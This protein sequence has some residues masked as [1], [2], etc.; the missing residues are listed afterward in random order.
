M[1]NDS[2]TP[3]AGNRRR[4]LLAT[5]LLIVV[6]L[7]GLG[8]WAFRSSGEASVAVPARVCDGSLPGSAVRPLLPEQGEGFKEE[9]YGY[10]GSGA[11]T[12]QG[13][14]TLTGGGRTV[15][16]VHSL[17]LH[18]SDSV[19]TKIAEEIERPGNTAIHLGEASGYATP[20]AIYLFLDCRAPE[21]DH[22]VRVTT[23]LGGSDQPLKDR[24]TMERVAG[25]TAD[26]ARSVAPRIDTCEA[27]RLPGGAPTLG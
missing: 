12:V 4:V 24:A 18:P 23:G 9:L 8:F 25:L 19:R 20:G 2:P 22:L 10:R 1:R 5:A 27:D 26:A 21:G 14:C 17:I 3:A 11:A 7:A 13:R 16:I 15:Q 6:L